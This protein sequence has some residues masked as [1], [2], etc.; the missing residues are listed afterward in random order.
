M[1]NGAA[2]L[3]R[4]APL[5]APP[6]FFALGFT[7]GPLI[8]FAP[9]SNCP[10]PVSCR[11]DRSALASRFPPFRAAFAFARSRA[12]ALVMFSAPYPVALLSFDDPRR[13][14]VEAIGQ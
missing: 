12:L 4:A 6:K 8:E 13:Q 14:S 10:R 7:V 9:G 3:E 2:Y 5:F 1:F 11:S